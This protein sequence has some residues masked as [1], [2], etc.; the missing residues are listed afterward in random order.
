VSRVLRILATALSI[1][2][3]I[4]IP[5]TAEAQQPRLNITPAEAHAAQKAGEVILI[6][7]RRPDE[8]AAT[9]VPEGA[10]LL[11]MEDPMFLA[12]LSQLT[13]GDRTR[14]IALF[15]R[16]ASRTRTVQAA[17]LQNGWTRVMNVEGGMI[18]NQNDAGWARAGLP[19]AKAP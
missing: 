17:L 16:T 13:G 3:L 7:I 4:G 15:C 10:V 8:W 18:G 1:A 14:P 6:D 5:M 11:Q 9:G 19:V 2:V 12:K